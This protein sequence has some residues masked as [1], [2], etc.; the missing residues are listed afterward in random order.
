[1]DFLGENKLVIPRPWSGKHTQNTICEACFKYVL[2]NQ[3]RSGD[4]APFYLRLDYR[5]KHGEYR[6]P[7]DENE[8]N[9]TTSRANREALIALAIKNDIEIERWTDDGPRFDPLE[10]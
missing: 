4:D 3:F 8:P 1:M 2:G 5:E 7:S 10:D 6:V 9:F